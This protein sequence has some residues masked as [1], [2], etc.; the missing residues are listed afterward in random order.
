MAY[1]W[2][3]AMHESFDT[4]FFIGPPVFVYVGL[5]IEVELLRRL[6]VLNGVF[7]LSDSLNW[8]P[9]FDFWSSPMFAAFGPAVLVILG[10][11][12]AKITAEKSRFSAY[13]KLYNTMSLAGVLIMP[14]LTTFKEQSHEINLADVISLFLFWIL[15][16]G[17][18]AL[19]VT[20]WYNHEKVPCCK[21]SHTVTLGWNLLYCSFPV[22][23]TI[24]TMSVLLS[25]MAFL[26]SLVVLIL[27]VLVASGAVEY[28]ALGIQNCFF[29]LGSI[30]CKKS[31]SKAEVSDGNG[32]TQVGSII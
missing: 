9:S 1:H 22:A 6:P 4:L 8:L 13:A 18:Y 27:L 14:P 5:A 7:G 24:L 11:L 28:C 17:A 3:V 26:S 2:A 31:N 19:G 12:S 30:L 21:K 29:R 20:F 16:P 15:F 25:P 10:G 23:F 32:A